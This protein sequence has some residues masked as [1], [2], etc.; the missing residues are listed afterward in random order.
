MFKR[1]KI[2]WLLNIQIIFLY[3]AVQFTYAENPYQILYIDPAQV[4]LVKGSIHQIKIFYDVTDKDNTLT[5]IGF[6]LCYDSTKLQ[7][8]NLTYF[9]EGVVQETDFE[10]PPYD[11]SNEDDDIETDKKIGYAWLTGIMGSNWPGESVDLPLELVNINFEILK[12]CK[13]GA[14]N[15]NLINKSYSTVTHLSKTYN[16][17]I[18]ILEKGDVNKDGIINLIDL[19]RLIQFINQ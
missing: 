17:Q 13:S 12:N 1:I 15:L 16:A 18:N 4:N 9:K 8:L 2:C 3:T 10:N 11:L 14:T 19:N 7:L 5:G 6:I